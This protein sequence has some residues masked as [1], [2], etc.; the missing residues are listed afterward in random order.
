MKNIFTP[1]RIGDFDL[2]QQG[3]PRGEVTPKAQKGH[4]LGRFMSTRL[5]SRAGNA[6]A[7]RG[8]SSFRRPSRRPFRGMDLA[9]KIPPGRERWP[10]IARTTNSCSLKRPVG[11]SRTMPRHRQRYRSARLRPAR[12]TQERLFACSP[13]QAK[14]RLARQNIP[15]GLRRPTMTGSCG[16]GV[17]DRVGGCSGACGQMVSPAGIEPATY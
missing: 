4:R 11:S 12:V 17:C 1:Y 14:Q 8:Y 16:D 6:A 2:G 10:G 9:G 15:G 5:N 13:P 7:S 3:T